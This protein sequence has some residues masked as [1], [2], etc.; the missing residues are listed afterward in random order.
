MHRF[1]YRLFMVYLDLDEIPLLVGPHGLLGNSKYA[2]RSFLRTDHLFEPRRPLAEEI[3]QII[4]QR[5]GQISNGPIRLL[6]Q[7]RQFGYFMSPLNLF[8]VFDAEDQKLE[9]IVAEVHNTPWNERHCYVLSNANRLGDGQHLRFQ[10]P[11]EFH[12]SPFMGMRMEYLWR[13]SVPADDVHVHLANRRES[14]L[15]FEADMRL[16]RRALDQNQLRRMTVR[17]PL[18]TARITAAI[19]VQALKLWWKRCPTHTHPKNQ[20]PTSIPSPLT[21]SGKTSL[22]TRSRDHANP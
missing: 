3:R 22:A 17:Y 15:V 7:L 21:V 5:T 2:S 19:Y 18:M 12:V 20:S 8:Y 6:T 9:F 11:K 4:L 16:A 13:L 1:Q 14:Q 10:H